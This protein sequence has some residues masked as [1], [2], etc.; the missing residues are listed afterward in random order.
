MQIYGPLYRRVLYPAFDRPEGRAVMDRLRR[1]RES[2]WWPHEQLAEYQSREL[3]RLLVHAYA[4]VPFYRERLDAA[5]TRPED[6]RTPADLPLLPLLTR[7]ELYAAGDSRRS[8]APPLPTIRKTTSGSTGEPLS[9]A[10][11]EGSEHWRQAVRMRGYGWAG[12]RQGDRVLHYWIMPPPATGNLTQ[13]LRRRFRTARYHRRRNERW[14][15]AAIR[16]D[17]RLATVVGLVRRTR[18]TA[19]VT[20]SLAGAELARYVTANGLRTWGTIPVICGAEKLLPAD[21]TA[22][23]EAFGP[24]VF[25]TYGGRETMLVASE[26]EVHDGLHTQDENLVVEVVVRDPETGA[27]RPARPGE[28]GEIAVTDLHNLGMPF[29]RYLN[30]DLAVAGDASPCGC[31]RGLGRIAEVIGR[32]ADTLLRGDGSHCAGLGIAAAIRSIAPAVRRY[33]IVQAEDRSVSI[34]IV[35][36]GS[37]GE[38]EQAVVARYA[39]HYLTGVPVEV[40]LVDEILLGP[41]GKHRFIVAAGAR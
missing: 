29:I 21:R 30:G 24:A 16:S 15:D 20:Y 35:P 17:E 23:D 25:E 40:E 2:E 8:T 13:R 36:T 4:N 38:S 14:A 3:R 7:E 41:N 1:L 22:I 32:S 33:Q 27:E 10:Y 37:F 12:Y 6:I 5:G 18:P 39:D 19:I 28:T 26:C 9:F 34:R 31:G 11:D